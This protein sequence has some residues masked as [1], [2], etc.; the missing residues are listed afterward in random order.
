MVAFALAFLLVL[1]G[2]GER[3][4]QRGG[5]V[6]TAEG[7]DLDKPNPIVSETNLDN[8]V[9]GIL[10]RPL[11]QPWWEDG[12]LQY[13]TSDQ[14]P[15]SLATSYEFFGPD[16]ASLRYRLR[17]DVRW[18][19][20][21][22]VTA[23][24]AAWSIQT[25]GLREVASPRVD[26]SRE[27]REVLV[28]DDSTVVVHFTRHYPEML[29]H[30]AGAVSPRHLFEGTDLSQMRS[31][32]ALTN[33]VGNLV[34]NGP[35]LL[36]EWIRGQR[37]VLQRNPDF[38]PQPHLDRIIFRII[39]EEAT[40]MIE[41]Q[42]GNVDITQMPFHYLAE[43]ERAGNI[44]IERQE[45]RSY[46]YISYNPRAHEFFA[47][48]DVRRALGLAI[49][50]EG[51]I[52]ALQLDGYA[53]P[54]GGP[55]SP[56]FR[57]LY[58]AEEQAPMPYD[59]VEARRILAGKGWRPGPDGI[60]RRDGVPFR[61][62]ILTNAENRRRVDIAQIVE[63]Q[64]RR[65][66]VDTRIQT[67]EFNT[68]VQRSR[69]KNFEARIGGWG[70]GLSPDLYQLWGDPD[71]PFNE[72]S[73]DNP[74]VQRLFEQAL[75]QPTEEAAAPFWRRAAGLIVA[76]QP[77]TWLYYYDTP[78][79]VNNRVRGTRIDTLGQYQQVWEWYIEQ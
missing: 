33:P 72:V 21:E 24:D 14:N 74:E 78:F 68:V 30:T 5:Q 75:E 64:W 77:Y 25:Q 28:E 37:V 60:L 23:H 63:Q 42:T 73:Y 39:P 34:T 6:I 19:D 7:A 9:N 50:T 70:V 3:Q 1:G 47:D 53:V 76:D 22:P 11:L 66:G 57:R 52:S 65:I 40:R 62:T 46:E 51:L 35:F 29:F 36:A 10:Y 41:L 48:R 58:D 54:A 16:G 45:K 31:H 69:D 67:L 32:P 4:I 17:T 49:D 61:F 13:L 2:C 38:E 79:A 12:E 71:L 26:Y 15:M 44:R 59:T 55:Y 43:V 20:G 18:S 27:I 56:I 8:Q